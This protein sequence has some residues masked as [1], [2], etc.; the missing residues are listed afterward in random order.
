MQNDP[1]LMSMS[2]RPYF[3]E[4]PP[5]EEEVLLWFGVAGAYWEHDGNPLKPH[6][7]LTSGLCSNGY[8]DV[9][10]LLSYPNMA[11]LLG[12]LLASKL[13]NAGI[14]RTYPGQ[15][16]WVISSAYS[17]ITFGHEVAKALGARF[18]NVEKDP[19]DESQRRMLWRRLTLPVDSRV[20]QV[21]ELIT[22]MGTAQEVKRAVQ[23]GNEEQ[24][25]F[26]SVIGVLVLRPSNLE[27]MK[28]QHQIVALVEKEIWTKKPEECPLHA[29][30]SKAF[31]P[32]THWAQL[33]GKG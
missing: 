1:T 9:P 31:K 5:L 29:A 6:A 7:E 11:E 12:R 30:G 3:D 20:L 14:Q 23:E 33:T 25:E 27:A 17:A 32:K 13:K 4:P 8:F 18:A 19:T 15:V 24:I 21:E 26:L 22:T 2:P 16:D 10:R 28:R